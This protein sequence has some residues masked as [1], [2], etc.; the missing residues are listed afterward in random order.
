MGYEAFRR[1]VE[2]SG[3]QSRFAE[4]VG[5]SQQNISNWL[6]AHRSLPAEFVLAAEREF[7]V[8]RHELRPDIYPIESEAA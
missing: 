8:P 6:A 2:A 3:S 4:A 5:T 1:A 7:G